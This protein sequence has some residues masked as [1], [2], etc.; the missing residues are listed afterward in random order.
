[1]GSSI[2]EL[3]KAKQE[4][5]ST[6]IITLELKRVDALLQHLC[7]HVRCYLSSKQFKTWSEKKTEHRVHTMLLLYMSTAKHYTKMRREDKEEDECMR[8]ENPE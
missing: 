4:S 1:M 8:H 6:T 7:T 2:S 3:H 5:S